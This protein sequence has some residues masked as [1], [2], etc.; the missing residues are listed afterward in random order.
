ML[1]EALQLNYIP[2]LWRKVKVIYI[3]KADQIIKTEL[4]L[5]TRKDITP[6]TTPPLLSGTRLAIGDKASYL[7]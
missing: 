1:K 4:V 7:D 5:F 2:S 6:K 3:P